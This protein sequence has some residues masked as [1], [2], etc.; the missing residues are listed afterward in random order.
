MRPQARDASFKHGMRP[1]STGCVLQAR[2]ASFKHGMRP[3][4]KDPKWSSRK[5]TKCALG[6]RGE[7]KGEG[8][9]E[10]RGERKRREREGE[11]K[12]RER[13]MRWRRPKEEE[14][15]REKEEREKDALGS[16]W[17]HMQN[18]TCQLLDMDLQQNIGTLPRLS[19]LPRTQEVTNLKT[20][21][22]KPTF[23]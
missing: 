13:E 20:H 21:L 11:R 7:G 5:M 8:K 15:R 18:A 9:G 10:E 6:E 4:I 1:S 14:V 3:W 19:S 12:R 23:W 16:V 22:V 17:A 2:D